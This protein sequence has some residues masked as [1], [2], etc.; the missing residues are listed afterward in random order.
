VAC[1]SG[2]SLDEF[3]AELAKVAGP[4]AADCGLVMLD[5][6][7][8]NAVSCAGVALSNHQPFFVAFQVL[9]IDSQIVHGLAV[10]ENGNAERF[11]WD[12]DKYGGRYRIKSESWISRQPCRMPSVT[13]ASQPIA[14][15]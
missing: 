10:S 13:Y 6:D 9:G 3:R 8:T 11:S 15:S 4:S 14:C 12:S 1:H 7:K 2:P 5:A